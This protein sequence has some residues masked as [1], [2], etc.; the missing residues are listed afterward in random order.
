MKVINTFEITAAGLLLLIQENEA[1]PIF[2]LRLHRNSLYSARLSHMD[3]CKRLTY[4]RIRPQ[5]HMQKAQERVGGNKHL[6]RMHTQEYA[7]FSL[8]LPSLEF[9]Y[10]YE[11]INLYFHLYVNE[12]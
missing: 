12:C 8:I 5:F 9:V 6:F 10:R 7:L 4:L 1:L 3:R 11:G 2:I